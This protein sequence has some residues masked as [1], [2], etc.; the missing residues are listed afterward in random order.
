MY[1]YLNSKIDTD[2]TQ[3]KLLVTT[4][5]LEGYSVH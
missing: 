5:Q 3:F 1:I 4:T 2:H